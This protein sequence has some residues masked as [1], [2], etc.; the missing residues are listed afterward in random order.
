M[1]RV[2]Q[3]D[4]FSLDITFDPTVRDEPNDGNEDNI[5]GYNYRLQKQ[6][7]HVGGEAGCNY[8]SKIIFFVSI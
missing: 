7:G 8:F 2:Y 3:E 1:V 5:P 4:Y 6:V